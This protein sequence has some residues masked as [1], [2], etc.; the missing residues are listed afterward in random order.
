MNVPKNGFDPS[1]PYIIQTDRETDRQTDIE[2]YRTN[3][4]SQTANIL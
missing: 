2:E 1:T 3:L 4:I